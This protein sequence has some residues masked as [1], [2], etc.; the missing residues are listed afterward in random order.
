MTIVG[1]ITHGK[2]VGVCSAILAGH[3]DMSLLRVSAICLPAMTLDR[4][5]FQLA[6]C[7]P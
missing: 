1:L 4:H 2:A 5:M 7:L 3:F 6:A